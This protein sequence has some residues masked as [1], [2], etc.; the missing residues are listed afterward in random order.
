[1]TKSNERYPGAPGRRRFLSSVGKGL[2]LAALSSSTV[3]SLLRDVHA[4][5]R[6]VSRLSPEEAARDEDFWFEIQQAFSVTRGIVN[7]NNGGVSPSPRLVTEALVRYAW[8]QEDATAYTMWQILEPQSETIRTGLADLFGCD[9]EEVAITRN[10]SDSL[11]ALLF[12]LDLRPGDEILTTTQDYPRMLTTLRQRERR[13]GV[14]LKTVKIPVP[15]EDPSEITAAFERGFTPRTRLVLVS[16]MINLTGQITPVRDICELARRRGAETVVDGAHSFA[17]FRFTRDELA[18]DYFGTSLHKWLH[19]PKG[20]GMLYVR[21][22]KIAKV[23][24]LMAAERAQDGDIRKFE[25]TGTRSAAPRLAV[26]EALLFHQGVGP[27]RKEARLRF[28]ARHWMNQLKG[29]PGVRFNTSFDD[30]QSCALANVH[31]EGTDPV[32]VCDHLM[33]R[34]RI[35]ATPIAHEEF[36]GVRVT[37]SVYTTLAELDRFC[38]VMETVARKGLPKA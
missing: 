29:L 24:P 15:P 12:G 28:L 35:F 20:T 18:C 25:E 26:G 8:Q 32:A 37:P 10:A 6:R 14:R 16:H 34:H 38:E 21:R 4:A 5:A 7:L 19:A 22:D 36:K 3:A 13:E 23:W 17:Q 33:A 2:G 30:R 31:V 9:R 27:A 1:M 11:E